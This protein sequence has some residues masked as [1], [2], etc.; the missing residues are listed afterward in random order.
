MSSAAD[1]NDVHQIA[2]D[3]DLGDRTHTYLLIPISFV[4]ADPD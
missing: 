4:S 1:I 2:A 3:A